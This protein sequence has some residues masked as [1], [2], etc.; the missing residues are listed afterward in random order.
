MNLTPEQER[1]SYAVRYFT[2]SH[3]A[4]C[5]DL[6]L[7]PWQFVMAMSNAGAIILAET[8]DMTEGEAM[9]R[10]GGLKEIAEDAYKQRRT[11]R[12]HHSAPNGSEI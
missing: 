11:G 6:G 5:A 2:E 3:R 12:I 8:K 10:I 4:I 9:K 1:M 7:T